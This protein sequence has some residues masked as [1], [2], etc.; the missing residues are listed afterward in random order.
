MEHISVP[1]LINYGSV[2]LFI[3]YEKWNTLI[4]KL[5]LPLG[6]RLTVSYYGTLNSLIIYEKVKTFIKGG[7][8]RI[9]IQSW[10]IDHNYVYIKED[11]HE[12]RMTRN[13]SDD[14][15]GSNRMTSDRIGSDEEKPHPKN[16]S[17]NGFPAMG[18]YTGRSKLVPES[19]NAYETY[20]WKVWIPT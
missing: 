6:L 13:S 18:K 16:K 12:N 2:P 10:I 14:T 15:V 9:E 20:V 1:L 3:K 8:S 7:G 19:K 5:H 4:K 11:V 17:F